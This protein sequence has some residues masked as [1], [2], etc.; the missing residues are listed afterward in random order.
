ML[1]TQVATATAALAWM[2]IEWMKNGK[3]SVLGIASGAVAGLVAITPGSGWVG[4][5]GA[6]AIGAAAGTICFFGVTSMKK[7]FG[8]DDS[9]DVV[10]VH[11]VGGMLGALL[12]GIFAAPIL[13]GLGTAGDYSGDYSFQ[14]QMLAQVVGVAITI[15]WSGIISAVILFILKVTI[16]IRVDIES[17]VIGLDQSEHGEAGYNL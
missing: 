1:V 3:P 17:E 8:Y 16:G 14:S 15:A 9:L 7:F 11:F 6:L 4:P 13:G 2:F 5:M 10:G 12:T